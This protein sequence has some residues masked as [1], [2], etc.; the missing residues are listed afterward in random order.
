M[1]SLSLSYIGLYSIV[2]F[3]LIFAT[4]DWLFIIALHISLSAII[5]TIFRSLSTTGSLR[6]LFSFMLWIAS[7][8]ELVASIV[9]IGLLICRV[10]AAERLMMMS[11]QLLLCVQYLFQ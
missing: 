3:S 2:T 4:I 6:I 9:I 5:P 11:V 10:Q 7:W 8:I 1:N